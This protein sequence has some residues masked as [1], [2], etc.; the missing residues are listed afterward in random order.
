MSNHTKFIKTP[1]IN[2]LKEGISATQSIGYGIDSYPICDYIMQ[3]VFLRITG[4]QEQKLKCICW[5]LAT[6]DYDYRFLKKGNLFLY[7]SSYSEKINLF[8]DIIEQINNKNYIKNNKFEFDFKALLEKHK[9]VT[10]QL[11]EV[12]ENSHWIIWKKKKFGEYKYIWNKDKSILDK[13]GRIITEDIYKH[14][15]DERNRVAHNTLSYQE[16]LPTLDKLKSD[17]HKY[18]NYFLYFSILIL[19]DEIFMYLYDEY[20]DALE[21]HI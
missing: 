4:A 7:Y 3:S 14:L 17:D 20:L 12:F 8:E 19:I 16:N 6:N 18:D 5:E 10:V 1:L 2:I 11:L 9:S 21:N 15:Y 13:N